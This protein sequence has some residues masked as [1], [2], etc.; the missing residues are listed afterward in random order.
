MEQKDIQSVVG[1]LINLQIYNQGW[2]RAVILTD[3][4]VRTLVVGEVLESLELDERYRINGCFYSHPKFG[5]QLQAISA[6]IDIPSNRASLVKFIQRNF[7]GAGAATAEKLVKY[8][9]EKNELD[10]L[11]ELL[12]IDP[13]SIDFSVVTQRKVTAKIGGDLPE[14]ILRDLSARLGS[15]I[16]ARALKAISKWYADHLQH[17]EFPVKKAWELFSSDPYFPIRN[18]PGYGFLTADAVGHFLRIPYNHPKR[19]AA[20]VSY[21]IQKG[22]SQFGHTYLT[23]KQLQI[24]LAALDGRIL[25]RQAVDA[26][27]SLDEP[28]EEENGY[29]YS[30]HLY[31]LEHKLVKHLVNRTRYSLP[32]MFEKS[33]HDLTQSIFIAEKRMGFSL[34]SS[35]LTALVGILT[36]THNV[37][38]LTGGPGCGKTALIEAFIEIIGNSKRMAFCAPT[39]IAA[40]V[41]SGRI[42]KWGIGA[43]TIHSLLGVTSEG[44]RHNEQ[45]PLPVEIVVADETSMDD[46]E[47]MTALFS[48]LS[49]H[50]HIIFLGDKDQLQSVGPGDCLANLLS[51]PFDH[52][53]LNTTHRNSGGLL[54]VVRLAGQGIFKNEET[55]GVSIYPELPEP[56]EAGINIAIRQYLSA[57]RSEHGDMSKVGFLIPTRKGKVDVP[58]W[59][60]TYVNACLKKIINPNGIKIPGSTL[61][62]D[63]R[64][65]IRANQRLEQDMDS[66]G[67]PIIE[68]VVNG[69]IGFIRHF[70]V[71]NEKPHLVDYLIIE[72]DDGRT[73]KYPNES[74]SELGLAYA[75][76]VHSAQGSQFEKVIFIGMNGSPN[77]IHRGLLFTGFSRA[78]FHLQII[79]DVNALKVIAQRPIPARNSGVVRTFNLQVNEK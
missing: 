50:A 79:G 24:V 39:G 78:K 55:D 61:C 28:I 32:P 15:F 59:N 73:I 49:P 35:Q 67:E 38:T 62:V 21:S 69:D 76:T 68:L 72:L 14:M 13:A 10:K 23:E 12:V 51:L 36:S 3:E 5:I 29:F 18:I 44:F 31:R 20:M 34:D 77:F 42:A 6:S 2:C 75:L 57:V 48:A 43:T 58:G 54:D 71:N 60:I 9:A 19:M 30:R 37:H 16:N 33:A 22:C 26:A 11:R 7:G 4:G 27:F 41:L 74:I 8:Y 65:I 46:L 45:N 40:K 56:T 64:I 47:L 63:D 53:R 66:N 17:Q 1:K 25:L 70:E 52:H